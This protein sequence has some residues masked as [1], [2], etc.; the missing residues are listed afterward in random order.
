M[1]TRL[2]LLA[3][4]LLSLLATACGDGDAAE[5]G[6]RL[7][8]VASTGVIAEFA[9]RVA[10]DY[11]E[12]RALIPAGVDLHSF[13]PSP[14]V[15][16]DIARADLVLVNGHGLEQSLLGLIEEN[17]GSDT[18]IVEVSAALEVIDGDP[19]L[20]LAVPNAIG[21]VEAIREALA[22]RDPEHAEGY[23]AR[24]GELIAELEAL[25][26]E[27]RA[28]L[29]GVG[30]EQRRIVVFHDAFGYLARAYGF[31]IVASVVP[32]NPNQDPSAAAVAEVIA[33]VEESGVRT[34]YREPQFNSP[35]LDVVA[36][37][38]G[39]EVGVLHSTLG[40]GVDSYAEL[41][42]ANARALLEGLAP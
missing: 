24:A 14:G 15:A 34:V 37:E 20:W 12:V 3:A 39:V 36:A 17:A 13:E 4:L 41:M 9:E 21:Y 35:V 32:A 11:A 16:R 23:A 31:D 28:L 5:D 2:A 10:G 29:E 8:V 33:A 1:R 27:V 25:D 38:A 19:H 26:A 40:D 7:S 42:R 18:P 30:V 22:G 6:A